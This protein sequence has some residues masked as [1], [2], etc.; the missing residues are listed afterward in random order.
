MLPI[1]ALKISD[2][3]YEAMPYHNENEMSFMN[4]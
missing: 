2:Q 4:H 3:E 1:L